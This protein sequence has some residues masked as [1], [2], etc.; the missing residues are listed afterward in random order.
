MKDFFNQVRACWMADDR[1]RKTAEPDRHQRAVSQLHDSLRAHAE[2][3]LPVA[4]V[5]AAIMQ[6]V[7]AEQARP[8]VMAGLDE[9]RHWWARPINITAAASLLVFAL[10]IGLQFG[11]S[12]PD[13]TGIAAALEVASP[14]SALKNRD[15]FAPLDQELAALNSDLNAAAV[16]LLASVP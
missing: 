8:R 11:H 5:H 4:E 1:F 10:F 16:F 7:R 14:A 13:S 9:L 12:K 3:A 15:L 6:A 2:P